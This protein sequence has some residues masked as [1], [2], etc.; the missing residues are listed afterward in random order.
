[1]CSILSRYGIHSV[2]SLLIVNQTTR[3]RHRG[4]EDLQS[5]VTFYK[6]TTGSTSKI[7]V[8]FLPP[9]GIQFTDGIFE[10]DIHRISNIV[11]CA[12]LWKPKLNNC[13]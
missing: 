9:V 13:Y 1:M 10:L 7:F 11:C 4:S 2:P 8:F 12:L 3:I 5:L 6:R